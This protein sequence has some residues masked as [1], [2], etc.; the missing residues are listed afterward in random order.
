[1]C[2]CLNC[3]SKWPV[4]GFFKILLHTFFSFFTSFQCIVFKLSSL[5]P[6]IIL[7]HFLQLH[8][9]IT[10]LIYHCSEIFSDFM[11]VYTL[12]HVK[13]KY[14]M[15]PFDTYTTQIHGTYTSFCMW[16]S[17]GI[18]WNYLKYFYWCQWF[19]LFC[20]EMLAFLLAVGAAPSLPFICTP[21]GGQ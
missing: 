21:A 20:S 18:H 11:Q 4:Y 15:I 19:Q 1:M 6:R 7:F 10:I 8:T 16:N 13:S 17:K 3:V 2:I 5:N 14:E 9:L 12:K